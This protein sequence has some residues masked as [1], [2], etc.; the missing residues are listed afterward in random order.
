[1]D[2]SDKNV[3]SDIQSTSDP[4]V[5]NVRTIT[6]NDNYGKT[7]GKRRNTHHY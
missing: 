6:S 1:M 3:H 4:I 2:N 7:Y 5:K